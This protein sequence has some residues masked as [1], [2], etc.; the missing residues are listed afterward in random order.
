MLKCNASEW[1]NCWRVNSVIKRKKKSTWSWT[2]W[3]P[4]GSRNLL[5]KSCKVSINESFFE[6]ISFYYRNNN[7]NHSKFWF[8][9]NYWK[10]V[11]ASNSLM[12]K[13]FPD[14]TCMNTRWLLNLFLL[15]LCKCKELLSINKRQDTNIIVESD[16]IIVILFLMIKHPVTWNCLN[17]RIASK[18]RTY[19][20]RLKLLREHEREDSSRVTSRAG[21]RDEDFW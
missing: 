11:N 13:D 10:N 15:N 9:Q 7:H 5:K 16:V 18:F 21:N 12:K 14:W 19:K 17:S 4:S 20:Y 3:A 1:R 2:S 8:H 6:H